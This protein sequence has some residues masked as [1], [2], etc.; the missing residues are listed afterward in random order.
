MN[1][2]FDSH[3]LIGIVNESSTSDQSRII[4]A[5]S[6]DDRRWASVASIWEISIKNNLGKL[7]L[8]VSLAKLPDLIEAYGFSILDVNRYHATEPL[9]VAPGT[10]DPFDRMLLAQCQ[11]EGLR[12]VTVDRMLK[13]HPLAWRPG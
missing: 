12:L 6:S 9:R 5:L 7:T 1:L 10:K 4:G 13:E 8:G 3:F 2:L 11:V